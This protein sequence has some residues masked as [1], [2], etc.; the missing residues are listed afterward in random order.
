MTLPL[1]PLGNL[2]S[3][4][5]MKPLE[6]PPRVLEEPQKSL[7]KSALLSDN[8]KELKQPAG[9]LDLESSEGSA[10]LSAALADIES[11]K[12]SLH[13]V[14]EDV[15]LCKRALPDAKVAEAETTENVSKLIAK[16]VS[17]ARETLQAELLEQKN[18]VKSELHD[19]QEVLNG[20]LKDL[21]GLFHAEL[22]QVKEKLEEMEGLD[23]KMA[24]ELAS[25]VSDGVELRSTLADLGQTSAS[26]QAEMS[27][28]NAEQ[29]DLAALYQASMV[30]QKSDALALSA[31]LKELEA[32]WSG[33][34][35][36]F[37]RRRRP[38][39]V[40]F[41][42]SDFKPNQPEPQRVGLASAPDVKEHSP[43]KAYTAAAS[44]KDIENAD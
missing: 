6:A 32:G 1:S 18:Q 30:R 39:E 33:L 15:E 20:E 44:H 36:C 37:C 22:Q 12:A 14:L 42:P 29:K 10:R 4:S 19:V 7:E 9:H 35:G 2:P 16:E 13:A 31:R 8:D 26:L 28:R 43:A 5:S 38:Q 21:N 11:L 23:A 40:P 17:S 3:V 27:A 25:L 41:K 24:K 34:P